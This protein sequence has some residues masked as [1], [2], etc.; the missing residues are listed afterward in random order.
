[1]RI[2]ALLAAL[3]LW[4][5]PANAAPPIVWGN[6]AAKLLTAHLKWTSETSAACN[7]A[8]AGNIRYNAGTFE[9]CNGSAW[10]SLG[11]S[12][13]VTTM[14]AVGSS[15]NAN[16]A[17]ISGSTLTLQPAS[18]T[19]PGV[20]S[21]TTQTFL[22]NKTISGQL[23]VDPGATD[24][25]A[26]KIGTMYLSQFNAK[27]AY[28]ANGASFDGSGWH[29]YL[30]TD[31]AVIELGE[32]GAT[33]FFND[34]GLSAPTGNFSPSTRMQIGATGTV[35]MYAYGAGTATFDAN[36]VIS[37]VSD[38]RLKSQIKPFESGLDQLRG[39]KPIRYHWNMLSGL[40]ML[41]EYVG[42][43]AQ[44]VQANL[45][46]GV[47]RSQAGYLSLQDRAI[48]ATLV[49]AVKELEARLAELEKKK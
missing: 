49:N 33:R 46:E 5:I 34:S 2:L 6:P 23:V 40:D 10:S 42:F 11:G 35:R 8:N 9:G 21:N 45:P 19:Q 12:S 28:F 47:G 36:G 48:I 13:G 41:G 22:G 7:A 17:S 44:N 37:S 43:S 27:A 20:V 32:D 25:Y 18:I 3:T 16:G 30:D 1:M 39:I 31:V 29:N 15:P 4:T 38:E 26:S 14:A 24:G